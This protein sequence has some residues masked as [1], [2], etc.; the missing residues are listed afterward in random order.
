MSSPTQ[1]FHATCHC[2]AGFLSFTIPTSH[3]PIP[4]HFCH[5]SMCRYINGTLMSIH[6]KISPPQFDKSAFTTYNFGKTCVKFFCTTCGAHM[7]DRVTQSKSKNSEVGDDN[8]GVAGHGEEEEEWFIAVSLVE[9]EEDTWD[10]REHIF[11]QSTHDGGLAT[12]LTDIDGKHVK[13]WKERPVP[14]QDRFPRGDWTPKQDEARK[15]IH[16]E[17]L[18]AKCLCGGIEFFISRPNSM[19]FASTPP[20][21]VPT[22]KSKYHGSHDACTSCRL[23]FSNAIV[24]WVFPP[25]SALSLPDGSAYPSNGLFGTAKVY[26]SSKDVERTFC[27]TCGASATYTCADRRGMVDVAAGLLRGE[28]GDV[29]VEEWVEWETGKMSYDEDAVWPGVI[30]AFREGLKGSG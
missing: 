13:L 30:A 22:D 9:A 6:A 14:D 16:W 11:V 21:L 2:R 29:R 18:Q 19:T 23:I 26:K 10:F 3:L 20:S 24:S 7:L 27:G 15:K 5:C 17:K 12:A 1:T 8:E 4:A 28:D 25:I